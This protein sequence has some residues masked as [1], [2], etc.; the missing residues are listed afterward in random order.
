MDLAAESPLLMAVRTALE[1]DVRVSTSPD[2]P[3]PSTSV[4]NVAR[5]LLMLAMALLMEAASRSTSVGG[6]SRTLVPRA[7]AA[8][9]AAKRGKRNFM[10]IEG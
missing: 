1:S 7:D 5:A 2:P 10:T 3:K 4:C 9:L 6:Y 8:A